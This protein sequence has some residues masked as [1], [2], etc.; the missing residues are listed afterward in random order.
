VIGVL[1]SVL[2]AFYYLRFIK[3]M[4][5]EK[6]NGWMLLDIIDKE[7]SIL[8][9]SSLFFL[10]FLFVFPSPLLTLAQTQS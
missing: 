9:G 10:L 3:I 8:L 6:I 2:S 7:K 4:Y 5:F 1:T